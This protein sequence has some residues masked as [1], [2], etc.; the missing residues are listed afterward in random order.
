MDNE[1]EWFLAV[2][3]LKVSPLLTFIYGGCSSFW[4]TFVKHVP[5]NE[6]TIYCSAAIISLTFEGLAQ[7]EKRLGAVSERS[8]V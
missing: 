1:T 7:L 2:S 6:V 4:K 8:G 3:I 5:G